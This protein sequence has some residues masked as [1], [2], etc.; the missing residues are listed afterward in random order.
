MTERSSKDRKTERATR[1]IAREGRET[2]RDLSQFL[3]GARRAW[4]ESEAALREEIE[5]RP[6]LV[7]GAAATVG[8]VLGA[9]VPVWLA[10]GAA[11]IGARV[12]LAALLQE[13]VIG[14]NGDDPSS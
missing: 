1:V 9:G 8:Y 5:S 6:W 10:R 14:A 2:M 3:S 12:A 13:Q 11:G 4:R 7:L